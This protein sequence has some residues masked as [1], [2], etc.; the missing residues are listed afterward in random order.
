MFP[1]TCLAT[2]IYVY[3]K[4]VLTMLE[5]ARNWRLEDVSVTAVCQS[6]LETFLGG[7]WDVPTKCCKY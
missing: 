6:Q 5:Y 2:Y 4:S 1:S 7:A 3:L